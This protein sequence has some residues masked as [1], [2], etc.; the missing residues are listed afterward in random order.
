MNKETETPKEQITKTTALERIADILCRVVLFILLIGTLHFGRRI[1]IA[2]RFIIP[3]ES[4]SPTLVPGDKVWVNKLLY[5]ARIYKSFDFEEHAPLKCF[6]MPGLRK[7]RPGDVVCFNYPLGYDKW[8]KI[9][10]KINYVYCKRVV[11]TPGDTIGI[12]DGVTWNNN[13]NGIIGVQDNQLAIQNTPDSILWR[14][15]FMATMPFTRPMWTMK[16]FGPLYVPE[17]GVTIELDSVGRAIYGPVIEYET[18]SWPDDEVCSHTFRHDYYFAF[19]DNSL[20]SNDSRY[21]GF[22]PEEFIIGIVGGRKVRNSCVNQKT[23]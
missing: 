5:G 13:Y 3:S 1:F 20:D 8:T 2:E 6:R 16:N 19:G 10:F 12:K 4:M 14:T 22:I 7:I 11:G 15:K 9:E 17:K 23:Y 21:W 18:G